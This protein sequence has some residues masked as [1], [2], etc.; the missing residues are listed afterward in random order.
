VVEL[1]LVAPGDAAVAAFLQERGMTVAA[2][3]RQLVDA[4]ALPAV[5]AVDGIAV[6]PAP[7]LLR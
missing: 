1:R 4:I 3:R 5:T 2:R 7:L 6:L